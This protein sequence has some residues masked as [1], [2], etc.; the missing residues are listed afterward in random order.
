MTD[1]VKHIL[2]VEDAAELRDA[3]R[4]M[5]VDAG[6]RVSLAE[7][8]DQAL[9]IL[10]ADPLPDAV[11]L[12]VLMPEMDGAEFLSRVREQPRLANIRVGVMTGIA[13]SL[14]AKLIRADV[15]LF[16]PFAERE[17]L[18]AVRELLRAPR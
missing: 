17:L 14:V 4:I 10:Q 5:L 11:L 8:G 18:Q 6:F 3:V 15:F 12:D 13:T 9:R 1:P 7:D 16:K 2:V